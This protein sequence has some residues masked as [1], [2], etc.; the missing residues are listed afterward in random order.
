[1]AWCPVPA[2][3]IFAR[4]LAERRGLKIQNTQFR[5]VGTLIKN[6]LYYQQEWLDSIAEYEP[7]QMRTRSSG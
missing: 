7:D 5:I 2:T 6:F 1:M 4:V 3:D